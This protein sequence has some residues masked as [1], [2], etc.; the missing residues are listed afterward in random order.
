MIASLKTH[1]N[2]KNGTNM[3]KWKN[4][5]GGLLLAG[6]PPHA[7][8]DDVTIEEAR[9]ALQKWGGIFVDGRQTS[10]VDTKQSGGIV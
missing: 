7:P 3:I 5:N 1:N 9:I 8:N 10:I 2:P 6:R 4:Y